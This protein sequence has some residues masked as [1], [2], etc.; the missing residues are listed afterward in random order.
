MLYALASFVCEWI[1]LEMVLET[2]YYHIGHAFLSV[3]LVFTMAGNV[4]LTFVSVISQ[5]FLLMMR[6][7]EKLVICL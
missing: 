5:I 7:K 3:T 1:A 2:V 4:W 6:F